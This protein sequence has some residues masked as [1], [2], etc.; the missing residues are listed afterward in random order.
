M[1]E[2]I[3]NAFLFLLA[4]FQ[5][6][7]DTMLYIFYELAMHPEIQQRVSYLLL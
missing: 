5:T 7:A 4:G 3:G 6:T 1:N 2:I